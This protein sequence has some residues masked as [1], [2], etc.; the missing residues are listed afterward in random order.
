MYVRRRRFDSYWGVKPVAE[1]RLRAKREHYTEIGRFLRPDV[2]LEFFH[3][4]RRWIAT[5]AILFA[6]TASAQSTIIESRRPASLGYQSS[7][8]Y[9]C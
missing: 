6:E 7:D 2:Y 4:A 1:L 3:R 9:P 8:R 5:R